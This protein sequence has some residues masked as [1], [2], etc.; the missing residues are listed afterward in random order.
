MQ[1]VKEVK[2]EEEKL[3]DET[4]EVKMMS[5]IPKKKILEAV[6][7]IFNE[8]APGIQVFININKINLI[9]IHEQLCIIYY[10]LLP[11]LTI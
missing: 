6:E 10:S 7:E 3:L 1:E 4:T 2:A 5:G 11:V 8:L 9:N